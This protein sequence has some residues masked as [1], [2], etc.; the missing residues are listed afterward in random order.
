MARSVVSGLGVADHAVQ[1]HPRM[2]ATAAIDLLIA[3]SLPNRLRIVRPRTRLI[4]KVPTVLQSGLK[5][6]PEIHAQ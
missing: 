4:G 1:A 6:N 2:I 5:H 3:K